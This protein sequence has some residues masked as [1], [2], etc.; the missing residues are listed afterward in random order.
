MD[1][2]DSYFNPA[3]VLY[4]P[5]TPM[6]LMSALMDRAKYSGDL[7]LTEKILYFHD[8]SYCTVDVATG[9]VVHSD[10]AGKS[11]TVH[12]GTTA[13][14]R[15]R[16]VMVKFAVDTD[17]ASQAI[18]RW[19]VERKAKAQKARKK[20][21]D[22][23]I[24][25]SAEDVLLAKKRSKMAAVRAKSAA[26]RL[27]AFEKGDFDCTVMGYLRPT[28]HTIIA[29]ICQHT[30]DMYENIKT[31]FQ[32]SGKPFR[33]VVHHIDLDPENNRWYNLV[34][35]THAQHIRLHKAL[36]A[37]GLGKGRKAVTL[38]ERKLANK[39]LLDVLSEHDF[40]RLCEFYSHGYNVP[41]KT[42]VVKA[43]KIVSMLTTGM[44]SLEL[45]SDVDFIYGRDISG[46][47]H[48]VTIPE[49]KIYI[50]GKWLHEM[51][52]DINRQGVASISGG[53]YDTCIKKPCE[54]L[55]DPISWFYSLP[56]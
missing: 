38:E 8:G 2:I 6:C 13:S 20:L 49:H 16:N 50:R 29:S 55:E 36:K 43:D 32:C 24:A 5:G 12:K 41:D 4:K 56:D 15:Y 31:S 19:A 14:K 45:A 52:L 40:E 17:S 7:S 35:L 54:D 9:T 25:G 10:S 23:K 22:L 34:I 42:G 48:T 39:A 30:R 33:V 44:A 26:D 47:D 18:K 1:T 28:D 27:S 21:K 46:Y 37:Y 51:V 11:V 53:G 3:E